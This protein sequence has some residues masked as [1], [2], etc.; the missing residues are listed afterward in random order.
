LIGVFICLVCFTLAADFSAAGVVGKYEKTAGFRKGE[1][2][3][4]Y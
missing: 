2:I 4:E 1:V 3:G